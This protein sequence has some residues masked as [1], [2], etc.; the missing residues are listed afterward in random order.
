MVKIRILKPTLGNTAHL[1]QTFKVIWRQD[2]IAL[3]H[4]LS[5]YLVDRHIG[6]DATC[7]IIIMT[8]LWRNPWAFQ[9]R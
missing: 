6:F 7:D 5:G 1:H 9:R 4:K 3:G 8:S 2:K